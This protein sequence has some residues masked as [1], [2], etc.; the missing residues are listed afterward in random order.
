MDSGLRVE[1]F[2]DVT[3]LSLDELSE[4]IEA[5]EGDLA[6]AYGIRSPVRMHLMRKLVCNEI[7]EDDLVA[8]WHQLYAALLRCAKDKARERAD[9]VSSSYGGDTENEKGAATGGLFFCSFHVVARR[10]V[11]N[12]T[13]PQSPKTI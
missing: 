9:Q 13:Q 6:R 11:C 7:V 1:D 3:P 8:R 2:G 5:I 4:S 12:G 10:I